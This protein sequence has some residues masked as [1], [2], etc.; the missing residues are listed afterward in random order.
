M[1]IHIDKAAL[2]KKIVEAARKRLL[3]AANEAKASM[4]A[5]GAG[6]M[7][8]P[9]TSV[10]I[11]GTNASLGSIGFP[12]GTTDATREKFKAA[13]KARMKS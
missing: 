13:F 12:K 5:E 10:V 1:K 11:S 7:I 3:K 8:D 9:A 6:V 4:G 2:T